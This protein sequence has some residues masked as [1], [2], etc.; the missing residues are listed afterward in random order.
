MAMVTANGLDVSWLNVVRPQRGAWHLD[1]TVHA[2]SGIA[3]GDSVTVEIG[4]GAVELVGRATRAA[5][6][7]DLLRVRVVAGNA[8]LAA[9]APAKFYQGAKVQLVV[10]DL[11]QAAGEQLALTADAAIL[12][13]LLTNWS[14]LARPVGVELQ[15][16]LGTVAPDAVWRSTSAGAIWL[17]PETW[18]ESDQAFELLE[19]DAQRRRITIGCEVPTLAPGETLDGERISDVEYLISSAGSTVVA[20]LA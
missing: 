18:P 12:G 10:G 3:P 8:G 13:G 7:E 2:S 15:T 17:G 6:H 4:G 1:A 14:T 9:V 5:A 19:R 11:L 16:L 20:M